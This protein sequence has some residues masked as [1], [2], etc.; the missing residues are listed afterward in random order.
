MAISPIQQ[1]RPRK[2]LLLQESSRGAFSKLPLLGGEWQLNH[3]AAF[4]EPDLSSTAKSGP[5]YSEPRHSCS[6][7]E[8][9]PLSS[10]SRKMFLSPLHRPPLL[11]STGRLNEN[12]SSKHRA[13]VKGPCSLTWIHPSR[14][15]T[16][17]NWELLCETSSGGW[18]TA[19]P[20]SP[21]TGHRSD[22][23]RDGPSGKTERNSARESSR[24]RP[25]P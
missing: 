9:L 11:P 3:S 5:L 19:T 18:D 10:P 14:G 22:Q 13:D 24:E 25:A 1:H 23:L 20:S 4:Q 15:R 17:F 12:V 7:W 2:Y 6:Y 16:L 8:V 21:S